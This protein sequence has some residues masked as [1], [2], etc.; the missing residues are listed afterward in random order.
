MFD[1]FEKFEERASFIVKLHPAE[2]NIFPKIWQS[3]YDKFIKITSFNLRKLIIG[4][5]VVISWFSRAMIDAVIARKP[6]IVVDFF[7][8]R[9]RFN[10]LNETANIIDQN[11]AL[12]VSQVD[13]LT[14]ALA[15]IIENVSFRRQLVRLEEDFYSKN[16]SLM[17]GKSAVRI[18]ETIEKIIIS[19]PIARKLKEKTIS[20]RN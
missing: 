19:K 17:D 14:S 20:S 11:I 18:A 10:L 13:E 6:L 2:I 12:V 1:S 9:E 15:N 8:D 3:K 7:D 5:D 16:F 4:S